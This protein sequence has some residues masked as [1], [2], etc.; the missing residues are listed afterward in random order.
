MEED[1]MNKNIT[2]E[3]AMTKHI[4]QLNKNNGC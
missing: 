2:F 1:K 3:K 4:E